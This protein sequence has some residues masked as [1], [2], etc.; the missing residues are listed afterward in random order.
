MK[1]KCAILL[2]R[3]STNIQDLD[4]QIEDLQKYATLKGYTKFHVIGTKESGLANFHDKIGTN[5]LFEF[6]TENPTYNTVFAT[7]LSRIG[8]R[9]SVLHTVKEWLIKNKVQFYLKDTEWKLFNDNGKVSSAGG[10]MFTFYGYFAESEITQKKIRFIRAKK[11]LMERGLS[12]SGKTLFGYKKVPFDLKR[13]TLIED[14]INADIV[15]TIFSWYND[16]IDGVEK[17]PSIKKITLECIK[18]NFPVYTHSKRN[19]NKLLK[20]EAYTGFK[21]TNNKRKNPYFEEDEANQ[22]KYITSENSIKYPIIIDMET[23]EKT[24]IKLQENNSKT[25]K[26]STHT[27]ILSKLIKCNSCDSHY[28][29]NYRVV[30]GVVRNSYRCSSRSRAL[31]CNNKQS[32]SMVMIDSAIWS[33]IKS[34]LEA[35]AKLITEYNP[36]EE[37]VRLKNY[38]L[39]IENQLNEIELAVKNELAL[40]ESLS[41]KRSFDFGDKLSQLDSNIENFSKKKNKLEK[42]LANIKLNLNIKNTDSTDYYQII[43]KNLVKIEQSKLLVKK[44]TNLFVDNIEIIQHDLKYSIVKVNFKYFTKSPITKFEYNMTKI[45]DS[46]L[47]YQTFFILDKNRTLDIKMVKT[48]VQIS[49]V[50]N[51]NIKLINKILPIK[52]LFSKIDEENIKIE[53]RLKEI[54]TVDFKK[55]MFYK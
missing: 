33:L 36:D 37:I 42:E 47:N 11:S 54:K 7:E 55:L 31:P 45:S 25:D 14:D 40:F 2:V 38:R 30:D 13:N 32:L 29:A 15:R 9:E 18:R 28:N 48:N 23:L 17:N 24:K 35:L 34:D 44:Y 21:I 5:E 4:P 22:E 1:E 51:G 6:I 26:S 3:V 19:V 20:E 49:F 12:I 43:T 39:N 52:V 27:T 53:P 8:R 10:I 46:E 50:G 16:G 41:K